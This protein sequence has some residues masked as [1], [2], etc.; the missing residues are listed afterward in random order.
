MTSNDVVSFLIDKVILASVASGIIYLIKYY[1]DNIHQRITDI[2][3]SN[4][5]K[6]IDLNNRLSNIENKYS[7]ILDIVL[8]KFSKWEDRL[9]GI[10]NKIGSIS[11]V[12]FKNEINKLKQEIEE[13]LNS[14]KNK[15]EKLDN[16]IDKI[17]PEPVKIIELNQTKLEIME[18]SKIKFETMEYQIKTIEENINKI[19]RIL[20][21]IIDRQKEHEFKI[22]NLIATRQNVLIKKE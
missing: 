1:F 6:F 19:T 2:Q 9:V 14:L 18:L 22:Q 5:T 3:K 13:D 15:M 11:F 21:K 4:E 8:E 17:A 7:G 12:E 20:K 10:L 16:E